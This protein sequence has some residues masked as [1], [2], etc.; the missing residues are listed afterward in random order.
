[1][2]QGAAP[3]RTHQKTTTQTQCDNPFAYCDIKFRSKTI[4]LIYMLIV[5]HIVVLFFKTTGC[6]R[7]VCYVWASRPNTEGLRPKTYDEDLIPKINPTNN[8]RT[9]E[10]ENTSKY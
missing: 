6:R 10:N 7:C 3:K 2:C 4:P 9:L 5:S 8:Y 1:M